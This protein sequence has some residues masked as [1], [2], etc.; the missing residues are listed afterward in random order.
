LASKA[1]DEEELSGADRSSTE[2]DELLRALASA[3]RPAIPVHLQAGLPWPGADALRGADHDDP[4]PVPRTG[5]VVDGRYRIDGRIG[6]GG[7]GIVFSAT[8]LATGRKLAF[9]WLVLRSNYRSPRERAAM[10]QRFSREAQAV[11]R[12]QHPNVVEVHDAG[13]SAHSPFLAMEL[14]EGETLR[15]RLA[16][17][18]LS[19]NEAMA[20]LGPVMEAI[21]EAHRRGVVHRDLK[22]DNVFLARLEDGG[23]CP[24]VLDFGISSLRAGELDDGQSTLTRTGTIIGTPAYMPLEQLRGERGADERVDVYSLGVMLFEM[25]TLQR[26]Y[27][28]RNA[29]DFAALITSERPT[30]LSQYR[31]ELRGARER[32]VMKALER[33]AVDRYSSVAEM[34]QALRES[35]RSFVADRA[36][37]LVALA[38]VLSIV[39]WWQFVGRGASPSATPQSSRRATPVAERAPERF[40]DATEKRMLPSSAPL[41]LAPPPW[42]SDSVAGSSLQHVVPSRAHAEPSSV[43][44]ARIRSASAAAQAHAETAAPPPASLTDLSARDFRSDAARDDA[45]AR[46]AREVPPMAPSS[47]LARDQF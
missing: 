26:P 15:E 28:A 25:L 31:P 37:L 18:A 39:C 29:A 13:C 34:L 41:P 6:S 20:Q 42:S 43:A 23:C 24:K 17:G 35:E 32:A 30:P 12:I 3:P 10:L 27:V 46:G 4:L 2:S 14:L 40:V 9:K 1:H 38:C 47:A 8:H 21:A 11:G 36:W 33:H 5:D 19:W 7:M 45:P 16:R 44:R 22:P